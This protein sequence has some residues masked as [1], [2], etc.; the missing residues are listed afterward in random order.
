VIEG[1]V[2]DKTGLDGRYDYKLRFT[3]DVPGISTTGPSVFQ[4]LHDQLG[5]TLRATKADLDVLI[6]DRGERRPIEN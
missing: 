2:V 6:V 3:M 4:A 5:L 1:L